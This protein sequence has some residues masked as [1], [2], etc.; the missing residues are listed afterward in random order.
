VL[1]VILG[2]RR[3]S[4]PPGSSFVGD[5]EKTVLGRPING[6]KEAASAL[7]FR[8]LGTISGRKLNIFL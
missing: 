8:T 1:L 2:L 3:K 7:I 5:T 6:L 4:R